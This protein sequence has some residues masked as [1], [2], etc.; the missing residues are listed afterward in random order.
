MKEEEE[1]EEEEEEIEPR[2]WHRQ[3]VTGILDACLKVAKVGR[4]RR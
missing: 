4:C 3:F 1:E 2:K